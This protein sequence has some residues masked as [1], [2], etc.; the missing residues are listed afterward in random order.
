[1]DAVWTLFNIHID[2][3]TRVAGAALLSGV[4]TQHLS[5]RQP[6]ICSDLLSWLLLPV[7]LR[8][9]RRQ[10]A[11]R[12]PRTSSPPLSN[13]KI[14]I[15]QTP[16]P[17][18]LWVV[19]LGIA[20]F[21]IFKIEN[22]AVEF[23]PA[24][25]P[26][27][28]LAQKYLG[29]EHRTS[30]RPDAP[31]LFPLMNTV[32]GTALAAFFAIVSLAG[33]DTL[34]GWGRREY[35]LSTIP[36]VALLPVY[37]TLTPRSEKSSRFLPS[38]DIEDASRPLSLRVVFVLGSALGLQIGLFGAPSISLATIPLS[39]AKAFS[40][41]FVIQTARQSSWL[42]VTAIGTFSI[43]STLDPFMQSSGAQALLHVVASLF[44]LGQLI[45]MLP[46]Q[47]KAKSVIWSCC[48]VFLAPYLA[49]IIAIRVAQSS[50]LYSL[51]HPVQILIR[52][53]KVK[54]DDLLQRQSK[55]YTA[56][57]DEYRRRY[58]IEP[59][60]GF[61]A[62]Y[63]FA[64]SHQSPI[65]DEFDMIYDGV[66]PF[67]RLSGKEVLKTI[68]HAR[69][70]QN[71]ELW[72]C[73][74][75]GHTAKAYCNHPWRTYDRNVPLL[76][77]T[78]LGDLRGVFPDIKFLV[79]HLDE[80]RV[81]I[82]P[83]SLR[84]PHS[85]DQFNITNLSRQCVWDTLTRFCPSRQGRRD[86]ETRHKVEPVTLPFIANSMLAKDLCQHPEYSAMH[87]FLISPT[88]F[89]L[90]EG[91]VP[92]LTTGS[93]STM[94]DI[95][96]PSPAYLESEFQYVNANDVEWDRKRNNLYWAGSTTGGFA[97]DGQWRNH[98]RQR[99]VELAQ[100]LVR[101]PHYY[102]RE[103]GGV[104]GR[105]RSWFL[106][107]R[108]FD[109]AFT[110]IFQC[111][112]KYCRDQRAYFNH[113]PWAD[114]DRAFQSRFVFDLD[115]NGISGR[116]YK[117]LASRSV[118]LKQT[119]LREWHDERLVPWVHYI[120][121]SQSMEELPEL[122]LYLASTEIGQALARGIAE[123]GRNWFSKA[124]REVDLAVYTYRLLLELAR[125]QDP[126]RPAG[127]VDAE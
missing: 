55:T 73:T 44:S 48:F 98:H 79:N 63:E 103:K 102:L 71:S 101:R 115:G 24:L 89:R 69:S 78:L 30:A 66:S 61:E 80:P 5:P 52:D 84:E 108:L 19:A 91:L 127:Q 8:A 40:W 17:A 3:I 15:P 65:I 105:V 10:D 29:L 37:L 92:V 58:G 46:K 4:L 94:S 106:N 85:D 82:P 51:E 114:K 47:A 12:F 90:I 96:Y 54:F 9:A 7:L 70:D 14:L 97:A 32:W 25:T 111:E 13:P 110:R 109:V 74:F 53:A 122:M 6:E 2:P 38:F 116:Y 99:F 118:P 49:N 31:I 1:M 123:Q 59:P 112:L 126:K 43:M 16:S 50:S 22:G 120:P 60:P 20:A 83:A 75:S 117:L 77:N 87:G 23:F 33:W 62:W 121:V 95:L 76:F 119:L 81:M 18:S 42:P 125:L 104:V 27:L 88:S 68:S 113:K 67:W 56:A 41:Y 93:P 124:F 72:L 57:H 100:N 28:L 39:L 21:C 26:L 86:V 64:K 107:T 34:S 35:A 36:V 45:H 11:I